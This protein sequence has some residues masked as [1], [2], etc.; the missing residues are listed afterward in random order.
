MGTPASEQDE[1]TAGATIELRASTAPAAGW[2]VVQWQDAQ[3]EWHDVER[4]W[5]APADFR[6]GPFRWVLY[7]T[8]DGEQV[9]ISHSFDLPR[10]P[11]EIVVVAV[12]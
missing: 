7:E 4:W 12:H 5:V 11:Y 8:R 2:S 3:G 1:P 6:K 10:S 9:A